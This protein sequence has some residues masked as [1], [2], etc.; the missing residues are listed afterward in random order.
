MIS[1]P[2]YMWLAIFS[3]QSHKEERFMYPAYPFLCL[4]AAIATHT[5]LSYLGHLSPRSVLGKVPAKVKLVFVSA[6]VLAISAIGVLRT[7]GTVSAYSA[8][9]QIYRALQSPEYADIQG[10][11]C[12]GKEWYR[13]PSS[14]FLPKNMRPKFV[15]SAFDGLLPGEY[16]EAGTIS[17]IFPTWLIP[18]GMNDQ[19]IEDPGKHV[20]FPLRS[21]FSPSNFL[22]IDVGLCTFMV[23]SIFSGSENSMLEPNYIVDE[24]NWEQ[25]QCHK[26][27][28]SSQT[29]LLGRIIWI[30]DWE[31]VPAKFR[32]QWGRYC[33]LRRRSAPG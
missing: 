4:N 8:P 10:N 31:V 7:V 5:V 22:K 29:H 13:F 6:F 15:K 27:L 20:R 25:I 18:P 26:F 19:N 21:I 16:S 11:V 12:L 9:L 33:L 14:Y 1:T 24:R 2:F 28:D 23:D 3:A 32:R 17:G 30:P